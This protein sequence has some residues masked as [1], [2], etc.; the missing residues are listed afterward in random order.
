[1]KQRSV[2]SLALGVAIGGTL[3]MALFW[4]NPTAGN[5][6]QEKSRHSVKALKLKV[7]PNG[8]YFVDQD[9]KPFFYLGDTCWLLFQRLNREEV[10]E[11]LKDRA[12]KGFTVIQAYVI[13][14]LDKRHPDGNSSLLGE[15][16]FIDR[17]PTKPNEAFFKNVDYV[18]NRANE[19][20]L[21]MGLVTAK[22]W[23]VTDHP[24]K[25]FDEKN[26]YVFGKFLGE[27][28]KNN[29]VMWFPGGDS[30][31]G[32]YEAVWVAM[33]K[34]LKDG[35]GGSQLV[36][37]HGQGS[38][39]SSMWFHKADWLDFNSI[40]SGHHFGSDSFAFVSKDYAL[41]PAKPT[42]DM[43]PA[44][45][46][47]PTGANKP[48]IDA[49]KVRTQAYSAMLAGAA[50]HGYGALDLFWLYKDGDGPFPKNGFQHWRKAMAYEGSTQ[51]GLVRRLFELRPWYK[52][53]P[54]QSGSRLGRRQEDRTESW[55]R[56]PRTAVSSSPTAH[57]KP[58]GI[59]MDKLSG[60]SVK[61][62]WYDPRKGTWREIG[63]YPNTG[64]REFVAPAQ[65]A[66]ERLGPGPRRRGEGLSDRAIRI[67][68][69]PKQ[70]LHLTGARDFSLRDHCRRLPRGPSRTTAPAISSDA[71][72][73]ISR[74]HNKVTFQN[75]LKRMSPS[76]PLALQAHSAGLVDYFWGVSCGRSSAG[77][78]DGR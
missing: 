49:H 24:E 65:G 48:R 54:A 58:V 62:R 74:R 32:K 36:C 6:S 70:L 77:T 56:G 12:A 15:S 42:V 14:G 11:Y 31:P 55:R 47:H 4:S 61:A 66:T 40:Q 67:T 64:T 43:E 28:Y 30:A 3:L 71:S 10:D 73:S 50:G 22:S 25:V 51:V 5:P 57:G 1:M 35:S 39:S 17:D 68:P 60:K 13:R 52:L 26:A 8:R 18:V 59:K 23:H 19:L 38:T 75:W 45:E 29:A 78:L 63:E 9:G 76:N 37:Y 34:G 2:R 20:G 53:V 41:T 46:N 27:R 72:A 44:Y 16:P 33:A 69:A 21:V 7:S